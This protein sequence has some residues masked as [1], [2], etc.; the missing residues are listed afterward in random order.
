MKRII[1]HIK[2]ML[3][4]SILLLKDKDRQEYQKN[5]KNYT[6]CH[7]SIDDSICLKLIIISIGL[8]CFKFNEEKKC[9][10]S[11]F[12]IININTNDILHVSHHTSILLLRDWIYFCSKKFFNHASSLDKYWRFFLFCVSYTF[13][14]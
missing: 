4:S 5:S 7:H 1:L 2:N 11:C 14:V 8:S 13:V 10:L 9:L 3:F 12:C 6:P